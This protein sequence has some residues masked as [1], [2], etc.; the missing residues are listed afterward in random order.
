MSL[1]RRSI[2]TAVDLG[3]LLAGGALAVVALYA[4]ARSEER[5]RRQRARRTPRQPRLHVR[6]GWRDEFDDAQRRAE[7]ALLADAGDDPTRD[8]LLRALGALERERRA[9]APAPQVRDEH[10]RRFSDFASEMPTAEAAKWF[11]ATVGGKPVGI[12]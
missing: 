11:G 10:V 1:L 6:S 2:G 9:S 5:E 12:A 7:T 3:C 8:P 4:S